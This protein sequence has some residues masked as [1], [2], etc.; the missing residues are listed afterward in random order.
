M[1]KSIV[2]EDILIHKNDEFLPCR[3]LALICFIL[4]IIARYGILRTRP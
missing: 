1:E 2:N 4:E 3:V